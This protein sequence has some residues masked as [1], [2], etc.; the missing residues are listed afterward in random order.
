[1]ADH[2]GYVVK[3]KELRKHTNA[4]RLQI[5][6][7]FGNDV[8][9]GIGVKVGDLGV[10][11]PSGLQ[12]S[13]RFC[14]VNDLV[15]R[16]DENG[17]QIGGFLDPN[18]RNVR[19]LKLRGE[20]SD[21]LWLP[22]V[23]LADFCT[24]SELK[25]G[26]TIDVVNGE[27]ICCKYVPKQN[28]FAGSSGSHGVRKA[29][30]NFAPTFFEHV[31]TDQLAYHLDA[32]RPGDLVQLTLKMHGTSGRTGHL[33]LLHTKQTWLDKLLRRHGKDYFEYGYVT[34]TRRVVLD[35]NRNGGYYGSDNFREAMA[36]KFEG[37]L[38]K[39][40]TVY[41]EIVGYQGPGGNPIMATADNSK[42]SNQLFK[43]K[44]GPQT[45][46]SY[47]CT[48]DNGYDDESPCCDI[49]VYRITMT[50]EDGDVV[51]L[52]PDQIRDYCEKWDIKVVQE[53]ERFIIPDDCSNPGEYVLRKVEEYFE[54]PDPIGKTHIREGVVARICNR[55]R[56]AVYKH[57]GFI[58]KQL[59][60][61]AIDQLSDKQ[62]NTMSQDILEEL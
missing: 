36:K 40:F 5:A 2:C 3:I 27:Q 42:V 20:K 23:C 37:K 46:F 9:V 58:F 22:I 12:L 1:M 49:Y 35:G 47:G 24:I 14:T 8:I 39:N 11:F 55:S 29:K 53:F 62:I 31:D 57:K 32:F 33:P 56:F 45:V 18:K 54:G 41:Y 61:I 4:D 13:E 16:K 60:G 15:R 30:I 34:G 28:K 51:E 10:Y 43:K 25:V 19:T 6:T 48:Q 26:D 50:N 52:S 17:N 21:G 38:P 7:I 59:A 44:Y